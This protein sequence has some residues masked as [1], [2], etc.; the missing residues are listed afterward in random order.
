V[1]GK[2]TLLMDHRLVWAL[3]WSDVPCAHSGPAP[4]PGESVGPR[5]TQCDVTVFVD[6]KT[7]EFIYTL[8]YAHK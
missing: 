3:S 5:F 1:A 7:G 8:S 4:L 6:A 2:V